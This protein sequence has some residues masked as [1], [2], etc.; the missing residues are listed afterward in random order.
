MVG[1]GFGGLQ[2]VKALSFAVAEGALLADV[3]AGEL[4][5]LGCRHFFLLTLDHPIAAHLGVQVDIDFVL[6]KDA[7]VTR[8][9]R[10][11]LLNAVQTPRFGRF[12]PGAADGLLRPPPP[13]LDL[14]QGPTHGGH[15]DSSA[16]QADHRCYQQL[17]GP[18]GATPAIVL[19][20]GAHDLVQLAQIV[21][22]ELVRPV[23]GSAIA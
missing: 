20:R 12:R 2:A 4:T 16:R 14:G 11:Q 21:F 9:G 5:R 17:A 15:V 8:Q 18:R 3:I 23:V 19:G 1:G 10:Q 22:V 7:L 13:C 6:I